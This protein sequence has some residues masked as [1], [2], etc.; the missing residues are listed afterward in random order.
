MMRLS[1]SYQNVYYIHLKLG[2]A[3]PSYNEK[4]DVPADSSE[5]SLFSFYD[6]FAMTGKVGG[7]LEEVLR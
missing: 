2:R 4:A 6:G 5:T 3:N 7:N 1:T